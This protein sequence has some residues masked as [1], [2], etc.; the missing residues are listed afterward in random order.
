MALIRDAVET[1]LREKT[2]AATATLGPQ[3]I[4]YEI[5]SL[6]QL[7]SSLGTLKVQVSLQVPLPMNVIDLTL[8]I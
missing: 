7:A 6:E 5:K 8:V 2:S 4:S 1:I 3:L